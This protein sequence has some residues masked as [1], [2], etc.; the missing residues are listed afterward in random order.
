M[1]FPLTDTRHFRIKRVVEPHDFI[2]D[3]SQASVSV[4]I[5]TPKMKIRLRDLLVTEKGK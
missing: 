3:N 2:Y 5:E 4:F 1:T